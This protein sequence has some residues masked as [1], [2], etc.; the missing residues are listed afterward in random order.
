MASKI[1]ALRK[2]GTTIKFWYQ[3]F[4]VLS[5]GYIYFYDK[6][7]DVYPSEY[8]YVKCIEIEK[9]VDQ[10]QQNS[11][12]LTN[13]Y[14]EICQLAFNSLKH[15]I[16]WEKVL[17]EKRDEDLRMSNELK[18]NNKSINKQKSQANEDKTK[19]L[20]KFDFIIPKIE[21]ELEAQRK[22]KRRRLLTDVYDI[23]NL[24]AGGIDEKFDDIGLFSPKKRRSKN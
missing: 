23:D 22:Q 20:S 3:Y 17:K 1:G 15:Q 14:G 13:K 8:F 16:E 10:E 12:I 21:I 5:G 11:L 18:E 7:S 4:A 19:V 9:D 6:Q 24:D 2:K